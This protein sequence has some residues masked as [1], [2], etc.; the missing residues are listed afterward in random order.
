MVLAALPDSTMNSI[1]WGIIGPGG[2]ARQFAIG[3]S[4]HADHRLLAVAS[5]DPGRAAAAATSLGAERAHAS[6]QALIDDPAI[7]AVYI[8]T[9]HPF[10]LEPCLAA[11]AAGKAVLCEKPLAI[12]RRQVEAMLAASAASGT[13]L[14]EALWTRFLPAMRQALDWVGEGAIG[15]LQRL[16]VDFGFRCNGDPRSRLLDPALAGGGLLDVGV[17]C[18]SLVESLLADEPLALDCQAQLGATGVDEQAA[19]IGRWPSGALALISC[20]VRCQT[21]HLACLDGSQGRLLIPDFWHCRSVELH[22]PDRP[23]ERLDLPF[24]VNGYE[25]EIAEVG[26]CLR[27]GLRESPFMSHRA[28]R[29]IAGWLDACRERIGLRYPCE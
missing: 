17:Y 5:R 22:R 12:N 1:S 10:H 24:T 7:D 4:A 15:E 18:F 25:Y 29:R 14:M 3:L 6:Y 8:A 21:P 20:G 16:S 28:S 27:A 19:I 11:L 13:F 23:V 26:R 2:I 9:P